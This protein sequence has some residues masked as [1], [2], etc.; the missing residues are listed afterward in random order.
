MKN[1]FIDAKILLIITMFVTTTY[2]CNAQTNIVNIVERCGRQPLNYDNGE[3]YLKDVNN[4]YSS[5]VGTWK[6]TDGSKEFIL[7]LVKQTKYR[8]TQRP[9]YY[10]EDRMVGYY[11]YKENNITIINTSSD[12]LT[13]YN[14]KVNYRLNCQSKLFGR[15]D[16]IAKNKRYV[17]W[18]EV[19]SPTQIRFKGREEEMYLSVKEGMPTP[20]PVYG[21]NSFPLDMV[22]IK[23]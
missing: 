15:I 3:L 23:Q 14:P 18:F 4:L 17:S 10:Y 9:D 6:W 12:N 21:G 7:T 19:V 2:S 8:Y 11:V 16:D 5:Y 1:S 13:S 22:L 20:Q